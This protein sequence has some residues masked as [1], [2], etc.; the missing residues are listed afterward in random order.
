MSAVVPGTQVSW[1]LDSKGAAGVMVAE[2]SVGRLFWMVT[3]EVAA[4]VAFLASPAAGGITGTSL[5]VD[6]G[7]MAGNLP[8]LEAIT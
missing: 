1:V 2:V 3:D 7:L 5:T 6:A 4:A 8:F